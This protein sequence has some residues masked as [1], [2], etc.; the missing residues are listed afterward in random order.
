MQY[1]INTLDQLSPILKGFRKSQKLTQQDM[2]D[3]LGV[4]QQTYQKLESTPQK[5]TF[6]R[7]FKVLSFLN[8]K[9]SFEDSNYLSSSQNI[10]EPNSANFF[11]KPKSS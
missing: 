10:A 4:S 5:V 1:T 6:E 3:K 2:A 9:I 11:A 8:V 7:L